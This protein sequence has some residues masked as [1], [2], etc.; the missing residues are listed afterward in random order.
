MMKLHEAENI[1]EVAC[2]SGTLLPLMLQHKRP[3]TY[4]LATDLSSNMVELARKNLKRHF[5]R[6][7][8]KLTFEQWTKE[9]NIELLPADAE[10][11]IH[12]NKRFDRIICNL[13][14]MLTPDPLKIFRNLYSHAKPG[15]LFGL[16]IWGNMAQ[17]TMI[18]TLLK[19]MK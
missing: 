8:S 16:S 15:C 2:G 10:Q 3:E 17:T 6:Y 12:T 11:P 19:S 18:T 4:Y 7:Q 13:G 5:E 14:L 1:L 9:Q